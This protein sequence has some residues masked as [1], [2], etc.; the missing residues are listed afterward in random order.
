MIKE[1]FKFLSLTQGKNKLSFLVYLA[2]SYL[3]FSFLIIFLPV[4]WLGTNSLKS[5]F[6]IQSLD[7]RLLPYEYKKL[8]R[9]TVYDENGKQIIYIKNLPNMNS[10][11]LSN[12]IPRNLLIIYTENTL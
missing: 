4:L 7:T 1:T 8:A 3:I 10:K 6:L 11:N 5:Q 9:A 2:Y 12:N